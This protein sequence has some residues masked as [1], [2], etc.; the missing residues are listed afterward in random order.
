M[1]RLYVAYPYEGAMLEPENWDRRG[2]R[3]TPTSFLFP[4]VLAV[5]EIALMTAG[6]CRPAHSLCLYSNKLY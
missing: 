4:E 3:L 5:D 6:E 2:E 1:G